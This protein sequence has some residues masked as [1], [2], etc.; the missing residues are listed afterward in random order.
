LQEKTHSEDRMKAYDQSEWADSDNTFTGT[1]YG[2]W[3]I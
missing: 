2:R 3:G 1:R